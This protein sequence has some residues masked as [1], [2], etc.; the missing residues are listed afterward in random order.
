MA[1]ALSVKCEEPHLTLNSWA[2]GSPVNPLLGRWGRILGCAWL[3][4]QGTARYYM[5][6]K[7]HVGPEEMRDPQAPG[8][9]TVKNGRDLFS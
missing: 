9:D 2:W 7:Q 1:I 8:N 5:T 6:A 3:L 4:S